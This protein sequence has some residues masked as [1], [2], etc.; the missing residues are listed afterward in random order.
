MHA[1]RTAERLQALTAMLAAAMNTREVGDPAM[2]NGVHALQADAGVLAVLTPGGDEIEVIASTGYPS[3][4]CMGA[5]RKWKIDETIPLAEATRT[6]IPVCIGSPEEWRSRYAGGYS[7]ASGRSAAWAALPIHVGGQPAG[8]LLWTYHALRSFTPEEIGFMET[9][10]RV[11][12]QLLE[13]VRLLETEQ[14]ARAEAEEA[15]RSKKPSSFLR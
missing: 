3:A 12:S 13:R 2:E 4:A 6:G 10:A 7:P 5:G 8:A 11:C 14:R 15:N 1:R 9:L